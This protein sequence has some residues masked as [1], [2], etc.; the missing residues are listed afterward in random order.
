[1]SIVPVE[2]G[3][4]VYGFD[5]TEIKEI[6]SAPP[7][8]P[9]PFAPPWV[10]GVANVHGEIVT[11]VS[12]ERR[13]GDPASPRLSEPPAHLVLLNAHD[14]TAFAVLAHRVGSVIH[15]PKNQ[16]KSA[17]HVCE[18]GRVN[19]ND[20]VFGVLNPAAIINGS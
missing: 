19:V 12:L 16:W 14:H 7:V 3:E 10:E 9:V 5:V 8:A 4:R 15:V 18:R 20:L 6:V 13:M 2:V 11:V 1:M 17:E